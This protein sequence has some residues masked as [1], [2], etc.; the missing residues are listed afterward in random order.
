MLVWKQGTREITDRLIWRLQDS[1]IHLDE[2]GFLLSK[3]EKNPLLS[4]SWQK[5]ETRGE[6][7][8]GKWECHYSCCQGHSISPM[9][10]FLFGHW[11]SMGFVVQCPKYTTGTAPP[12]LSPP[13]IK[14]S[15]LM[16]T[17]GTAQTGEFQ[18]LWAAGT[19]NLP[20]FLLVYNTGK[21]IFPLQR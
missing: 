10:N 5:S 9:S 3:T 16:D 17:S 20:Q 7:L 14:A 11:A 15:D 8:D 21:Q 13:S 19:V 1:I 4:F 18:P 12:L 6:A 2:K